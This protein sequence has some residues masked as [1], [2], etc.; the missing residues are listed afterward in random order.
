MPKKQ[1]ATL[2]HKYVS[3][4]HVSVGERDRT[5]DPITAVMADLRAEQNMRR[6]TLGLGPMQPRRYNVYK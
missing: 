3:S 6:A 4:L 5:R 2:A 1:I